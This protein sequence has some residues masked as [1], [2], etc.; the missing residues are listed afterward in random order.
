MQPRVVLIDMG[1]QHSVGELAEVL[2]TVRPMRPK[3]IALDL[4]LVNDLPDTAKLPELLKAIS[5]LDG[6]GTPVMLPILNERV[7]NAA[8]S[9]KQ[10]REVTAD[11]LRDEDGV[12]R[13]TQERMCTVSHDG[14]VT[15]PTLA[16]AIAI[17]RPEQWLKDPGCKPDGHPWPILFAPVHAK[18]QSSGAGVY[19]IPIEMLSAHA[20]LVKDS[21]YVILG[22]AGLAAEDH[23]MTPLGQLPGALI[24]AEAAWTWAVVEQQ[25]GSLHRLLMRYRETFGRW[26]APIVNLTI[27][28]ATGVVF[29]FITVLGGPRSPIHDPGAAMLRFAWAIAR[30]AL[31]AL[32][33]FMLGTTWTWLAVDLVQLGIVVGAATAVFAAILETLVHVGDDLISPISWSVARLMRNV[34]PSAALALLVLW[35]HAARAE[36]CSYRSQVLGYPEGCDEPTSLDPCIGRAVVSV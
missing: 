15:L 33:L 19:L 16:A 17:E 36:E 5:D 10:V 1:Q 4:M 6:Q 25:T 28:M 27:G 35:T 3:A 31:V 32:S 8:V 34:L 12:V 20:D 9:W 24:Q 21:S 23:F 2:E 18:P 30:V 7:A 11:L 26:L 22:G 29:S 14:S 13:T